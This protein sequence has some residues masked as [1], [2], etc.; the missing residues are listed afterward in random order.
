MSDGPANPMHKKH[1]TVEE[2]NHTLPLVKAVVGDI[3]RQYQDIQERK[4]R[5]AR[6]RPAQSAKKVDTDSMYAE[7]IRH[8]E[9]E[10]EKEVAK[11]Q[12]YVLELRSLGVEIK[13]FQKGLVD[14]PAL[15]DGREVYLCWK[16]GEPEVSFWHELDAGFSGRQ[17]LLAGSLGDSPESGKSQ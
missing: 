1:F 7:E 13:D 9:E 10:L 11:L 15:F 2:A 14:F 3:V 5:L 17:S 8:V 16:L 12:E 4:D 6:I